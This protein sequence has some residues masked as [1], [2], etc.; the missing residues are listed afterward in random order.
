MYA[1]VLA[2]FIFHEAAHLR[3]RESAGFLE[4]L[5]KAM[6]AIFGPSVREKEDA[7][8]K[9]AVAVLSQFA[10]KKD[11]DD[12]RLAFGIRAFMSY[13]TASVWTLAFD[14]FRGMEAG[15]LFW[16]FEYVP[17]DSWDSWFEG[18][19][20][21]WRQLASTAH[22]DPDETAMLATLTPAN[23][24]AANLQ[25]PMLL[26]AGRNIGFPVVTSAEFETI[27]SRTQASIGDGS[28]ASH[29]LRAFRFSEVAATLFEAASKAESGGAAARTAETLRYEW[30]GYELSLIEAVTS[31]DPKKMPPSR[32]LDTNPNLE[33]TQNNLEEKLSNA[34]TFE[35]GVNCEPKQCSVGK[36]RSRRL[37]FFE[38]V[39]NSS[40]LVR[41]RSANLFAQDGDEKYF[42]T[43][44]GT[45][46][47]KF[48]EAYTYFYTH[49]DTP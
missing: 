22:V 45:D 47:L 27:V 35:A 2:P 26:R 39:S 25:N 8:D 40:G 36:L 3:K 1:S 9:E 34:F 14:D 29:F 44:F 18:L 48:K 28:H 15:E 46:D 17:C 38:L 16:Q 43:D 4:I 23:V 33:V 20:L 7:A 49:E 11:F 41:V 12:Q 6:T 32:D 10:S 31:R 21:R 5:D 30:L 37:G 13:L 24:L 42:D 19:R